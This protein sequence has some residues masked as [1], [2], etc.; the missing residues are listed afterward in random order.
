ML[1]DAKDSNLFFHDDLE[2]IMGEAIVGRI[3][4]FLF[5][6]PIDTPVRTS[7]GTMTHRP[8]LLV[9]V[10][11][12][13]GIF[14]WG[15]V[16][17]NFPSCGAEHR[18]RLIETLFAPQMLHENLRS[19]LFDNL[20]DKNHTLALQTGEFGPFSQAASGLDMALWD[21]AAR[22]ME[23][24]LYA[25]LGEKENRSVPF[26]ASG[27]NPKDA[28]EAVERCRESGYSAFKVKVGFDRQ[29]DIA[30]IESIVKELGQ[31]ESFM[32]DA[33]QA[34]GLEQA[35]EMINSVA[36]SPLAWVEEPLQADRPFHEWETLAK[37]SPFP[38]AAG[39][40][41]RGKEAFQRV[42]AAGDISVIQPDVCKWGGL[43]GCR[44]VARSALKAGR[45]YCPH[46]LGG[47]IGLMAS[48]HLLAASGGDGMLE[49]DVNE[50]PLRE[51]LAQPFPMISGGR[52]TL[53]DRWGLGVEPDMTMVGEYLCEHH[54]LN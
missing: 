7:F 52:F 36:S 28:I 45:R 8:A 40:N 5:K 27:I 39:E 25:L 46:Y 20:W 18:A 16:W 50:N 24:P 37:A 15:E 30:N 22:R 21:L 12:Q 44:W 17:S 1:K 10:E 34:W 54:D 53:G 49:I 26:Y 32:I 23:L 19:G 2:E 14:G 42:I 29:M 38:L 9:R 13:N 31:N 33:N 43:T 3:E 35:Q 11:D 51:G 6:A 4:T 48:A 47:G 41:V